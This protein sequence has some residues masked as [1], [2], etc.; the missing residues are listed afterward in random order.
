MSDPDLDHLQ[1]MDDLACE[2]GC[3]HLSE[4][5]NF[6]DVLG[7]LVRARAKLEIAAVQ[8][9]KLSDYLY[10]IDEDWTEHI[11]DMEEDM[12]EDQ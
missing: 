5:D 12:E 10:A 11:A 4:D 1:K 3:E 2:Y 8:F 6:K 7:D 9:E